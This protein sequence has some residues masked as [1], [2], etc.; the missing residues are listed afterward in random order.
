VEVFKK[1]DGESEFKKVLELAAGGSFGELALIYNQ[2]R[3]ASG[4]RPL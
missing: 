2:P 1:M 3:A 4:T